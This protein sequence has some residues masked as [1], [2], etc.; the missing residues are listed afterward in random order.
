MAHARR[1]IHDVHVR[2]PT[3]ITTEA[4]KRIGERYAIEAEIRGSPADERLAI[5]KEKTIQLMQSLYDWI[6]VQ[7]TLGYS[8][9]VLVP[10]EAVGC[11]QPV[12]RQRLGRNR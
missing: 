5:R 11:T 3:D 2:T 9:G 1:K 8:E 12:L 7:M 6:Q 4:L 10:A